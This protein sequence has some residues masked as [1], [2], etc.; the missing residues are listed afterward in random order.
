MQPE[1][2]PEIYYR[3]PPPR[4]SR[5]YMARPDEIREKAKEAL[6]RYL[7]N[8]DYQF[9][10]RRAD[11][12]DP[13]QA[14]QILIRNVIGYAVGLERS[15]QEDDLVAMRRHRNPDSYIESFTSCAEKVRNLKPPEN[16]QLNF[17][18]LLHSEAAE[19]EYEAEL[20]C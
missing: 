8:P 9:L 2:Y 19:D 15:I 6:G 3:D 14:K 4:V 1:E 12:L 5:D 17:F 13:K 18:N 20:E 10:C 7:T 11:G 16:E